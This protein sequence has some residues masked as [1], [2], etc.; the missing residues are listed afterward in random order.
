MNKSHVLQ[1]LKLHLQRK[2]TIRNRPYVQDLVQ[3]IPYKEEYPIRQAYPMV[4]KS[5]NIW[6]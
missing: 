6:N 5:T 3:S 1:T 2:N 4:L